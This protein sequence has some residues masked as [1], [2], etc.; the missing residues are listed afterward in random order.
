ML[1]LL[2]QFLLFLERIDIFQLQGV[3]NTYHLLLLWIP[4][5][6]VS[7]ELL[8]PALPHAQAHSL[9]RF[10]GHVLLVPAL[11]RGFELVRTLRANHLVPLGYS[12]DAIRFLGRY[13]SAQ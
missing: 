13:L 6:D 11:S 8:R 7:L 4:K 9:A 3:P 2:L 12:L 10:L 1:P 5:L